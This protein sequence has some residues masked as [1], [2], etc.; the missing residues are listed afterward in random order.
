MQPQPVTDRQMSFG[1]D[2]RG[3]LPARADIPEEFERYSNP[4][5]KFVSDWFYGGADAT[6][7]TEK[8]GIDRRMALRHLKT[9]IG[10][11]EPEHNHKIAGVAYL[12]SLWFDLDAPVV[13]VSKKAERRKARKEHHR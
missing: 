9:V 1:S 6:R 11:F 2:V 10:S 7:L 3:L 8:P 13:K 5:V 12:L 4:Y